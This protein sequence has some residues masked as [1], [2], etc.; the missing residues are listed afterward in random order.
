MIINEEQINQL[1]NIKKENVVQTQKILT[2]AL[3]MQ[4]LSLRE[5]AVLTMVEDHELL[6]ELF[7]VA[8][9]VKEKIYGKRLVLFAPLYISNLCSN[10]C[11]YCAFR[12]SNQELKRRSLSKEEIA[13]EVKLLVDQGQKRIL[14]VA[15]ESYTRDG[16]QYILDS[17]D[18]A[19]EVKSQNGQIRRLN[20]NIA[21]LTA[22]DFKKLKA[23][24]IGT[25][26]LFQETYH[27]DTYK[28]VHCGGRKA[29][30]DWR[31]ACM[32]RAMEAGIDDV[33]IGV[34]FGLADWRF[35]LLALLQ[36]AQY[37]DNKFGVGPHTISVPRL[38]PAAGSEIA[39]QP[40]KPVADIDFYKL[41]A[42]LRLAVPYTGIILSTRETPQVRRHALSLG[43][44]QISAGSRTNPGGYSTDKEK[45]G[46][47]SLGDHRSLDEVIKDVVKMGYIPSFCTA[48]YRLGRTGAHFM[49]LAKPGEI[50]DMCSPNALVT[51]Q[52]Y[53]VDYAS[54]ETK[55]L[56]ENLIIREL[57]NMTEE[58]RMLTKGLIEK[59]KQGERDVFV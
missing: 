57:E 47:F 48:C 32:D 50:K 15:G 14:L 33:G 6:Q 43:V 55:M 20:V 17:I 16:F 19:Y 30:Y 38:E 54:V 23:K 24:N 25:Y 45:T 13:H 10:D 56:G 53:L 46:Q 2:K 59:I 5:V 31:V 22:E 18:T 9:K 29:D 36:H 7:D 58:Q 11:A 42:I 3:Q 27:R 35:E 40:P 21:P 52:E 37:L 41:I 28:K 34:L 51:F 49:E 12:A 44:S 39:S 4:G 26:Q 8:K 1:M